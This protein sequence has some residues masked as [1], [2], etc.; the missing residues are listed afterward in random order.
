MKKCHFSL[1]YFNSFCRFWVDTTS[2]TTGS[3]GW[4]LAL[5]PYSDS[6]EVHC[7]NLSVVIY[8][9][10]VSFSFSF[11]FTYHIFG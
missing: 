5:D 3:G 8:T 2:P 4:A 1:L 10:Y 9:L 7:I 6:A 11:F